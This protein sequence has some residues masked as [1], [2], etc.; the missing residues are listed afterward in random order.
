MHADWVKGMYVNIHIEN[1]ARFA[2]NWNDS[3]DP[4]QKNLEQWN[5]G[6][7]SILL[8]QIVIL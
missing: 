2:H 5:A 4:P 7:C 3:D 1:I 8:F 6:F